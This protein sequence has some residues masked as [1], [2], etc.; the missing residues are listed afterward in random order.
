MA[1]YAHGNLGERAAAL[2][3]L[4]NALWGELLSPVVAT[5]ANITGEDERSRR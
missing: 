4:G 3:R 5:G 1:V 2:T